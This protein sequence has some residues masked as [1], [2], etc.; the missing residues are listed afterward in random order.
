MIRARDAIVSHLNNIQLASDF[1]KALFSPRTA[2]VFKYVRIVY[3]WEFST[4]PFNDI[5]I[6]TNFCQ[7]GCDILSWKGCLFISEEQ[8]IS[9]YIQCGCGE[10]STCSQSDNSFDA[11]VNNENNDPCTNFSRSIEEID[12]KLRLLANKR[13]SL[14]A[15]MKDPLVYNNKS[16]RWLRSHLN[17]I[18][19]N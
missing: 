18:K 6:F 19:Q 7:V 5:S 4:S 2:I 10:K 9:F 14:D 15:A 8:M 11:C 3:T 13:P 17:T 1:Q 16:D 12:L